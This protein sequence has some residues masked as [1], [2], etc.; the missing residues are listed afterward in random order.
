MCLEPTKLSFLKNK[1]KV[2]EHLLGA[3]PYEAALTNINIRLKSFL[4]L[5]ANKAVET[6][7]SNNDIC[8][9]FLCNLLII[10]Y[11]GFEDELDT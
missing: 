11:F 5:I 4:V 6:I 2:F 1:G 7:G 10:F 8:V 9:V 3:E